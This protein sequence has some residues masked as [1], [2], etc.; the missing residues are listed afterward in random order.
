MRNGKPPIHIQRWAPA[1]FQNDE[2]V[3]VLKARRDWTTLTFYRQFL[4]YSF[5]TGGDLPTDLESLAAT[6]EM[7]SSHVRKALAFCL[8]RLIDQDGDR[9]YQRRV[10][11]E[12]SEELKFREIQRENGK[13]ASRRVAY[14]KPKASPSPPSPSPSPPPIA[15]TPADADARPPVGDDDSR[16]P[17]P[18]TP[19]EARL[20]AQAVIGPVEDDSVTIAFLRQE[21]G[22]LLRQIIEQGG[23]DGQSELRR[24]S[25]TSN[26]REITNLA[27]CTSTSWM[28]VVVDRLTSR[29]LEMREQAA[30]RQVR[31]EPVDDVLV[32]IDAHGGQTAVVAAVLSSDADDTDKGRLA[33]LGAPP[34][35]LRHLGS[36]IHH[37]RKVQ[38]S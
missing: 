9:L 13:K 28:R 22:T 25:R 29:L 37:A 2:H 8:G 12:V 4:D 10:R 34:G 3:K 7:P 35:T 19:Q 15:P 31:P 20:V 5:I 18:A 27:S 21:A 16:P 30:P 36:A 1:D 23:K 14:D 6:L 24:A 17:T 26:G 33:A 38:H 32:W 11:S